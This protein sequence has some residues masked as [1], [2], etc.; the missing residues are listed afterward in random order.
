MVKTVTPFTLA[1]SITLATFG[2]GMLPSG[3]V[4]TLIALHRP[5]LRCG[6]APAPR[7]NQPRDVSRPMGGWVDCG[8]SPCRRCGGRLRQK[9]S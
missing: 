4:E 8:G 1:R 6:H 3:S 5:R 9:R 2:L 7:R